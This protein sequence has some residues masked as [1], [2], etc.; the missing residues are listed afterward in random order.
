ML[1]F[2]NSL[3][4]DGLAPNILKVLDA[5][6]VFTDR[7]KRMEEA[8]IPMK[9]FSVPRQQEKRGLDRFDVIV[10]IQEH[11]AQFYRALTK[12]PVVTVGHLLAVASVGPPPVI[13]QLLIVA[14]DNPINI[15]GVRWFLQDVWP[16]ILTL[17]PDAM[18]RIVGRV[19]AHLAPSSHVL[20]EGALDDLLPVYAAASI[21]INPLRGG[22]GLKI[23]GAEALGAGRVVVSTPSAAVGLEEAIGHGLMV[24]T[25]AH[26]MV[27]IIDGLLSDRDTLCKLSAAAAL[28]AR[29]WNDRFAQSFDAVFLPLVAGDDPDPPREPVQDL[30]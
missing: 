27:A 24:A 9:W 19:C 23:K 29:E 13:P 4:L 2:W 17:R 26:E 1:Y 6:D 15:D 18:L 5:Q 3:L 30:V 16:G 25:D 28:F 11:E 12:R 14:S 8:G 10:A 22:T 21:V 20:L 7:N